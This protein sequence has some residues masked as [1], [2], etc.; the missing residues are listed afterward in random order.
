MVV[1]TNVIATESVSVGDTMA[2]ILTRLDELVR[3]VRAI[4]KELSSEHMP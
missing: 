4:L 3:S 1:H 2:L